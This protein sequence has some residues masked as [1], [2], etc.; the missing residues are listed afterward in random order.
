MRTKW[1]WTL[2]ATAFAAALAAAACGGGSDES[3]KPA[4]TERSEPPA[5][6]G[7]QINAMP[8][9]RV[10]DGGTFTYPIDQMPPNFNYHELDGTL[11]MNHYV[12]A[13]LM[14]AIFTTDGGGVP[15]WNPDYLAGEPTLVT[16][17][18][19][20]ITYRLNPKAIWYDGTP[21]TWEDMYWQ[22]KASNGTDKRYRISSANGYEEIENIERGK[23]DHEAIVTYRNKFAD[24][25]SIFDPLYPA[26]T[27]KDPKIFNDGWKGK[28]LTT[29][30]PFKLDSIDQTTKTITMVRNEKWWGNP[31]KLDRI[32]FRTI[33]ADA[34]IDALANGEIDTMDIGPDAN[35]YARARTIDGVE[36][37]VAGG[38][39]FRHIT[40]NGTSPNLQD[41]RVRQ[42]V[43]MAIN[44]PAIAKALLGPLNVEPKP[45]GNHIFMA[46]Q[47]GYKDNSGEIGTYNPD[48]A[49][50]LLD[51]AGWKLDGNVRKKDGKPLE[52]NIVI[53]TAVATSKQESELV[54]NMLGQVGIT[55]KINAIP[56]Q[57]FFDKYVTPG[58]FDMTVFSWMGTP[59]PISSVKSIYGLPTRNAKGELDVRQ[60]FART[61]SPE[62]DQMMVDAGRELDRTKAVEIANRADA[63]IWQLVHSLTLYQRPE[64]IATKKNLANFGA[65]GFAQPWTYQDIG[66]AKP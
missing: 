29:A 23:D 39:N 42:A 6:H 65:F 28:P 48:K 4:A 34:Q 13:A 60:N 20:V 51:E 56:L 7:N 54:Q 66:W 40:I 26:S 27:N 19:Q 9:D 10:Q 35:K 57:D 32:V 47:N 33:E 55:A 46:N 15:H 3:T 50:A 21:I 49:K 61:G 44:R 53:P 36:I 24:W 37:R 64:L 63:T 12:V 41:V 30:G 38:P 11:L 59:Y 16:E 8:R 43:S 14:P 52:L 45:L 17:P 5:A 1:T 31:A 62:L 25:S 22:W 2:A 18:K 58:Q